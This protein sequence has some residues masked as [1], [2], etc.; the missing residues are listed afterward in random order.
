VRRWEYGEA[1]HLALD[2]ARER[3]EQHERI[4]FVVEQL[5]AQRRARFGREDI[6]H[7]A[8]NPV[9]TLR[10]VELVALVLHVSEAPQQLA[11]IHPIAA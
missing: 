3:I 10:E 5:D 7:V 6:D 9:S 11:L 8:A 2:L 1:R 4:D